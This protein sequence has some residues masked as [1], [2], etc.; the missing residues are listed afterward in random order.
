MLIFKNLGLPPLVITV[1]K[2]Y[3]TPGIPSKAWSVLWRMD[4][5]WREGLLSD[6]IALAW[7]P[8]P[9]FST[10]PRSPSKRRKVAGSV[11][12]Q[13]F[14]IEATVKNFCCSSSPCSR[15]PTLGNGTHHR[16]PIRDMP[17]GPERA[18]DP[19]EILWV[20]LALHPIFTS[21]LAYL[22]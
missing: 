10:P 16:V 2:D 12:S 22:G 1:N 6:T 15:L 14:R 8:P 11:C 17:F 20:S 21:S 3:L 18:E 19:L 4:R 5:A 7:A 13:P 9:T